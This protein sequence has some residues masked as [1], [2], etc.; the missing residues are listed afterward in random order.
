MAVK[1]QELHPVGLLATLFAIQGKL[2]IFAAHLRTR[3]VVR[4]EIRV[5]AIN[6]DILR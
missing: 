5:R 1:F 3:A 4:E 6:Q 2:L